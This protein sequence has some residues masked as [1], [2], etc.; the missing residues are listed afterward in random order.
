MH[1]GISLTTLDAGIHAHINAHNTHMCT[2]THMHTHLHTYMY[3]HHI[4]KHTCL[5]VCAHSYDTPTCMYTPICTH[6][7]ILYT[8]MHTLV[9]IYVHTQPHTAQVLK[10][11][12]EQ[13]LS[14]PFICGLSSHEICL[15]SCRRRDQGADQTLL[16]AQQWWAGEGWCHW[17]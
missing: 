10:S 1:T 9:H 6:L 17:W 16:F 14:L 5:I 13:A 11:P 4:Q 3:Q 2:Y 7:C 15:W 12:R 8:H